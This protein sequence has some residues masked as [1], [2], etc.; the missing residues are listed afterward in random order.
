M[1][2]NLDFHLQRIAALRESPPPLPQRH[3]AVGQTELP[4]APTPTPTPIPTQR[5]GNLVDSRPHAQTLST[6]VSPHPSFARP[7]RPHAAIVQSPKKPRPIP[8]TMTPQTPQGGSGDRPSS[9]ASSWR[10]SA[11][12]TP[13]RVGFGQPRAASLRDSRVSRIES[14]PPPPRCGVCY[15]SWAKLMTCSGQR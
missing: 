12:D 15:G 9:S 5:A 1:D 14:P 7:R 10:D 13:S 2:F 4:P 3:A 6:R 11:A 8:A